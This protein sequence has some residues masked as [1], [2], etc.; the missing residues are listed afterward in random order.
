MKNLFVVAYLARHVLHVQA[1]VSSAVSGSSYAFSPTARKARCFTY[2][3]ESV[4]TNHGFLL[5]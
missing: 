3:Y 1:M 4:G 2:K 5:V